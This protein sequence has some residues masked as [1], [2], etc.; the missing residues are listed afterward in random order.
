MR[1]TDELTAAES[2]ET[3]ACENCG[4]A[5]QGETCHAC[6]QSVHDPM[7]PVD[8]SDEPTSTEPVE[9]SGCEN[10]GAALQGEYCHACGQSIHNP[11]RHAGH[12]LEE[13]F[14]SFWHLDG[15]VFRTLR[16]LVFPARVACDYL[17]GHRARYIAPLRLFV[18]L[19]LLTFF[20][21]QMTVDFGDA[22]IQLDADNN[23][24]DSA[25]TVADVEQVRDRLLADLHKAEV[26]AA[27]VPG[28]NMGL[29]KARAEIQGE[30][31]SR[32]AELREE[33]LEPSIAT[34]TAS[35]VVPSAA[36]PDAAP[37]PPGDANADKD[38]KPTLPFGNGKPWDAKTN[39]LAVRWLPAFANDWLNKKI[40]R[41]IANAPRLRDD[42]EVRNRVILGSVPTAL[43]VL[44]PVFALLLKV[45]YLFK[46]RLYLEHLVVALYSHAFL[47]VALLT[48][49]VLTGLESWLAPRMGAAG[50]VFGWLVTAAWWSMPIYLLIMQKRVY[51]QGWLLTLLKYFV[52]GTAYLFLIVLAAFIAGA[53][54]LAKL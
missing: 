22:P 33:G 16:D 43:F 20:V 35:A 42:R 39:P 50:Q 15:R 51:G 23:A 36:P 54:G 9:P 13:V 37:K 52:L 47:L 19:S 2:G 25:T 10:C 8:A 1:S 28:A 11:I 5:L 17:A 48:I 12:A 38:D 26:Q 29:I 31:A 4:A 6:A 49:F 21:G 32:I 3:S 14:E 46:R 44:M 30:A 34:P 41:V 24:F 18:V 53:A 40:A 27:R 45:A 7:R